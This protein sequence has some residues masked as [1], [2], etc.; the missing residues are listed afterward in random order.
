MT[1]LERV[2][3]EA[4]RSPMGCQVPC[5]TQASA[6]SMAEQLR[7]LGLDAYAHTDGPPGWFLVRVTP[8][9]Q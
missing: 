9:P 4:H 7:A 3:A 8:R 1:R 5:D 2:I 6:E